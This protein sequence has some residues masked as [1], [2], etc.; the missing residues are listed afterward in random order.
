MGGAGLFPA[1][2]KLERGEQ[3]EARGQGA[4]ASRIVRAKGIHFAWGTVV[5]SKGGGGTVSMGITASF[6]ISS[7]LIKMYSGGT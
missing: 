3:A 2:E 7:F 6:I 1:C 5:A 4:A